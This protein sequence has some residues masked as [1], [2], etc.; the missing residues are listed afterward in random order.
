M[1]KINRYLVRAI[2]S[3]G[4]IILIGQLALG[5]YFSNRIDR[6]IEESY[7]KIMFIDTSHVDSNLL[8]PKK[9]GTRLLAARFK[10]LEDEIQAQ[11]RR[12]KQEYF[13]FIVIG[14]P[15]TLIGLISFLV[16]S[17]QALKK[18]A[19]Q[20][21][22]E[23]IEPIVENKKSIIVD[24]IEEHDKELQLFQKKKI[25][26]WGNEPNNDTITE[27]LSNIEF[28]QQNIINY[29][30]L[31]AGQKY[32]VLIINNE[33][34]NSLRQLPSRD[35]ESFEGEQKRYDEEWK[36]MSDLIEQQHE[37][38]CIFYYCSCR[39]NFPIG[40]IQSKSLQAKIN[41][42]TNP[43]QIYGNLLNTLKYQDYISKSK[44]STN[45]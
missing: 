33:S 26:L 27:V 17:F 31:K 44:K 24:L 30:D 4:I 16:A 8:D 20:S 45:A 29:N 37:D 32:D 43:S 9:E 38:I 21:V 22:K 2:A 15:L 7:S 34:A 10:S 23:E 28:N 41:F 35:D 13:Y 3:F 12:L 36:E 6:Q 14:L 39:V 42:V 18:Q 1:K 5:W 40:K 25:V 19:E 11:E